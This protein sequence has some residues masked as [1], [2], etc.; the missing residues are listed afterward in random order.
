V[1][2]GQADADRVEHPEQVKE[3]ERAVE[4]KLGVDGQDDQGD[5][6]NAPQIGESGQSQGS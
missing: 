5:G 4:K 3:G 6:G 2:V 1:S